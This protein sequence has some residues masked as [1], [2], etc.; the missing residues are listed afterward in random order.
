MII[1]NAKIYRENGSFDEGDIHIDNERITAG[2]SQDSTV[3]DAY[4]LYAIPG[5]TDL[6]FHGCAGYDFCDGT[7]EAFDAITRYEAENG[8]TQ[9][10]P[11]TMTL[12]EE[13]LTKICMAA[14]AY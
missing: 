6:H 5:L 9:L 1:K 14:A 13:T 11:A 10:C 7:V 8:I 2:T 12:P 3:I 4:G